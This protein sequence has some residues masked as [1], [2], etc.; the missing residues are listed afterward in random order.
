[1]TGYHSANVE[2]AALDAGFDA[3]FA[4]PIDIFSFGDQ[5]AAIIRRGLRG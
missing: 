2:V 4:K 3:F 5:L 1:M